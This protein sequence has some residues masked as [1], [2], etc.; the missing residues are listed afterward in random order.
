[1]NQPYDPSRPMKVL[2]DQIED[3][4]DYAAAEK[5][6]FTTQQIVNTTYNLVC[7]TD[8]FVN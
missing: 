7:D 8:V 1:M 6:A 4:I 3:A 5:A 2:F